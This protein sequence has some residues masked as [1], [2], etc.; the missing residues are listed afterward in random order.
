MKRW[1]IKRRREM[2]GKESYRVGEEDKG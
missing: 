2:G 1:N